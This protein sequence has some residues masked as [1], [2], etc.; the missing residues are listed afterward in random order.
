MHMKPP[1]T[2]RCEITHKIWRIRPLS[3][4][5]RQ[6]MTVW[7]GFLEFQEIENS[8]RTALPMQMTSSPVWKDMASSSRSMI[9]FSSTTHLRTGSTMGQTQLWSQLSSAMAS[10][11]TLPDAFTTFERIGKRIPSSS[12]RG[13]VLTITRAS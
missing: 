9:M 2:A 10:N 11:Q 12:R 1:S 7:R 6:D 3:V 13:Q 8:V 5:L 4:F